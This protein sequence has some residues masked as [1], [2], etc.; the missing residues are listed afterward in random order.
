MT[1][2]GLQNH[3]SYIKHTHTHTHTHTHVNTHAYVQSTH[4]HECSKTKDQKHAGRQH[5]VVNKWQKPFNPTS[6]L[7]FYLYLSPHR[8]NVIGCWWWVVGESREVGGGGGGALEPDTALQLDW[9]WNDGI[10]KGCQDN[11]WQGMPEKGGGGTNESILWFWHSTEVCGG[12][13]H[14]HR[15]ESILD[16]NAIYFWSMLRQVRPHTQC[17]E[18]RSVDT[19]WHKETEQEWAGVCVCVCVHVC[20]RHTHTLSVATG[21]MRQLQ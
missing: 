21:Q 4:L 2:A 13:T 11:S 14:T 15:V 12:H 6:I 20:M 18:I 5:T 1:F 19:K 8:G 16:W 3:N 17:K 10:N 7:S 9:S